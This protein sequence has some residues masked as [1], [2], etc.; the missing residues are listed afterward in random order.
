[1]FEFCQKNN[2]F[3]IRFNIAL[4]EIQFKILFNI[5]LIQKKIQFNSQ[6]IIDTGRIGKVPK[7][8]TNPV[9]HRSA[10]LG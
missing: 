8:P 2:S 6:G 3:N 7:N 4:P 5:L 9:V 1:M 10:L